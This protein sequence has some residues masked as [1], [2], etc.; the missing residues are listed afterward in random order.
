MDAL[1]TGVE[2]LLGH[3][4]ALRVAVDEQW[5]GRE[6][7]AKYRWLV[8]TIADLLRHRPNLTA[9]DLELILDDV[10]S[11]EFHTNVEDGSC[12]S[13][14]SLIAFH[15]RILSFYVLMNHKGSDILLLFWSDCS[16]LLSTCFI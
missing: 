2:L 3:W 4:P 7:E 10:L 1:T 12:C 9:D 16:R 6:S 11:A 8:E 13:V 5:G 15:I 14:R